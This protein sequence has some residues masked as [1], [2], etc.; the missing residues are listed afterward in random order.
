[1][2]EQSEL[3]SQVVENAGSL[4]G[5]AAAGSSFGTLVLSY[6]GSNAVAIGAMCSVITVFF[7]VFFGVMNIYMKKRMNEEYFRAK[8]KEEVLNGASKE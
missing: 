2:S 3:L 8:I 5:K 7:F 6:F 4:S 1:M